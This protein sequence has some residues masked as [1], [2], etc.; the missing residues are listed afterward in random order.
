MKTHYRDSITPKS[1][2]SGSPH[3]ERAI[4]EGL[5]TLCKIITPQITGEPAKVTCLKCRELLDF[6]GKHCKVTNMNYQKLTNEELTRLLAQRKNRLSRLIK[7]NA[8]SIVIE[9]ERKLVE[10]AE[11]PFLARGLSGQQ[12]LDAMS[13]EA[14]RDSVN[15]A[16]TKTYEVTMT[17]KISVPYLGQDPNSDDAKERLVLPIA[18]YLES[19]AENCP[20]AVCDAID[21]VT[22]IDD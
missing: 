2:Y 10:N 16:M 3:I 9:R 15:N 13:M 18:M 17:F 22:P 14:A 1:Q 6:A 12:L 5:W 7:L 8:P 11:A 19:A 20:T 21:T 4:T